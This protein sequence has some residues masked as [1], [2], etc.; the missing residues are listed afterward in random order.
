MRLPGIPQLVLTERDEARF[1]TAVSLPDELGCMHWRL[2]L[3][4][5]GYGQFRLPPRTVKAH[6]VSWTLA[7]G[8]FP[9]ALEPDH[10]CVMRSCVTPDHLEW[11]TR[12]ENVRRAFA[13]KETCRS[14]RHRW[15]EQEPIV[16]ASG[17]ECRPCR[18]LGRRR[19]Y[20]AARAS[21]MTASE[22]RR[23]T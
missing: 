13:R 21:G 9:P 22:A 19:R 17:R 4:A 2:S 5:Y 6:L 11:V 23:M 1:R 20:E 18:L 10:L 8:Q 3:D 16:N 15:D 12:E 14:G 7:Y